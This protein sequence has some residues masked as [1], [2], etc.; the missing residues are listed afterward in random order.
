M[1]K[2]LK[3][4]DLVGVYLSHAKVSIYRDDDDGT[5]VKR[6]EGRFDFIPDDL[7]DFEIEL[8]FPNW[9]IAEN[10]KPEDALQIIIR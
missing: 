3:L 1:E 7:L 10:Y 4:R 2:R 8:M 9:V 5:S 6:Y